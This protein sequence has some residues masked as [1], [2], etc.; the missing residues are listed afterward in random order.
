MSED[1]IIQGIALDVESCEITTDPSEREKV[2]NI[3]KSLDYC[4]SYVD[5]KNLQEGVND[6]NYGKEIYLLK[7]EGLAHF[8]DGHFCNFSLTVRLLHT[9]NRGY[10]TISLH[11]DNLLEVTNTEHRFSVSNERLSTIQSYFSNGENRIMNQAVDQTMSVK[12]FLDHC[13]E[14]GE[15]KAQNDKAEYIIARHVRKV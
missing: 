9:E 5:E 13:I 15:R 4:Q 11:E 3:F 2:G 10:T 1:G 14:I 7:V 12:N 6:S 8:K